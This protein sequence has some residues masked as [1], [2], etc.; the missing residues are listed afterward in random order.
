MYKK[1]TLF[2]IQRNVVNLLQ[3]NNPM[4]SSEISKKMGINRLTVSKYLDILLMQKIICRK[5]IG[6]VNF[7]FLEEGISNVDSKEDNLIEV[8]QR[9]I[10]SLLNSHE[11]I[12]VNLILS[13]I[14]NNINLNKLFTEIYIPILNT[15]TE[16]YNRGKISKTEK[17]HLMTKVS[18]LIRIIQ[19]KINLDKT[20]ISNSP[21]II[22]AGDE[23]AIPLCLLIEILVKNKL[24]NATFIGNVENYIDPFFD[25]DFLRYINK[26]IHRINEK[27]IVCIVSNNERSVKFLNST[28]KDNESKNKIEVVIFSNKEIKNK[29]E[30]A[31]IFIYTEFDDLINKIEEMTR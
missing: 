16:L 29:M 9:L 5:K 11:K 28:L 25:I 18:N 23:D 8:Q 13:L 24:L 17:V 19:N 4:S 27:V 14:N 1:Y 2:D 22:V 21:V 31:A 10:Y 20:I 7:W 3:N 26:I 6:S 12:S 15:I 30:T